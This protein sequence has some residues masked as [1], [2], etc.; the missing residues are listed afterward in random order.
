[1]PLCPHALLP[2]YPDAL[3]SLYPHALV[4]LHF[5]TLLPLNPLTLVPSHPY[6][7]LP[8]DPVTLAAYCP[9]AL[10]SCNVFAHNFL[11]NGPIFNPLGLLDLSPSPLF[12]YRVNPCTLA[13]LHSI[14][15]YEPPGETFTS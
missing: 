12:S 11:N 3:V 1:M 14:M 2:L 13:P 7:L 9:C 5:C 4:S 10:L 6:T 8:L 15:P